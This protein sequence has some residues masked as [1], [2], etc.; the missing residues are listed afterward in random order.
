MYIV[1]FFAFAQLLDEFQFMCQISE[2]YHFHR[3]WEFFIFQKC[4]FSLWMDSKKTGRLKNIQK[5]S[6]NLGLLRNK[7]NFWQIGKVSI[8]ENKLLDA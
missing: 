6:I 4:Y 5:L 7:V 3:N 1:S 8:T 2:N